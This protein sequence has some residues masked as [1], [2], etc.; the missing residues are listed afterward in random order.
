MLERLK[1]TKT[2]I[3]GKRR[4][5][6]PDGRVVP[7]V[8]R[9]V[10]ETGD[11][12]EPGPPTPEQLVAMRRGSRVH[13][14]AERHLISPGYKSCSVPV[15]DPDDPIS[16]WV[17]RLAPV[18]RMIAEPLL[19]EGVVWSQRGYAG[20]LDLLARLR[21]GRTCLIDWKSYESDKQNEILV[22]DPRLQIAAYANAVRE[23]YGLSVDLGLVACSVQVTNAHRL[24]WSSE[25][26]LG[27]LYK[28]FLMRLDDWHAMR[29]RQ[30]R[31]IG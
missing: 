12:F 21:C 7:S 5:A 24:Y 20:R 4:Y 16:P 6:L 13:R 2:E 18:F 14:V 25:R 23:R 28:R 3:D 26:Q 1:L 27:T 22:L 8:S 31:S 9:V 10:W 11:Y 15:L 30:K 17:A 19:I 29:A